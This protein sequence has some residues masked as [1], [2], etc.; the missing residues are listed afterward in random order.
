MRV[1]YLK[2]TINGKFPNF[3]KKMQYLGNGAEAVVYTDGKFAYKCCNYSSN[4][5]KWLLDLRK[6]KLLD[7]PYVPKVNTIYVDK[8]KKR[9]F[10]KMELLSAGKYNEMC[11]I[12]DK[13]WVEV[14][15]F[16]RSPTK[17]KRLNKKTIVLKQ[18]ADFIRQR[19]SAGKLICIDLHSKNVMMRRKQL[20]I[21]DPVV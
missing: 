11:R 18:I 17:K 10:I 9:C 14:H 12:S 20:V 3:R 4:Y 6:N 19:E 1:V 21:T 2:T 8:H 13:M 7:N 5:V 15:D 16:Y